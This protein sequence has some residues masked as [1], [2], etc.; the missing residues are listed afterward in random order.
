MFDFHNDP[1]EVIIDFEKA[2]VLDHSGIEAIDMITQRYAQLGK[3][4][5]LLNLSADC[6]KLL[7]KA[8]NIVE[9]SI[10]EDYHWHLADDR[11]D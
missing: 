2:H 5:H 4:L 6:E 3:K 9:I 11:L 1:E 8:K 7:T 10:L